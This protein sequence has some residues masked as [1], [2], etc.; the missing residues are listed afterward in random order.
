MEVGRQA[1]H[2]LLVAQ[3]NR[4]PRNISKV[5][6]QISIITSYRTVITYLYTLRFI[7]KWKSPVQGKEH[8]EQSLWISR[9][10][11]APHLHCPSQTPGS[12]KKIEAIPLLISQMKASGRFSK[13]YLELGVE[14]ELGGV[15]NGAC[16]SARC[17]AVYSS[18]KLSCPQT[19]CSF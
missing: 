1:L 13:S 10:G 11:M 15:N 14:D 4:F 5:W 9:P 2:N 12:Q 16:G 8:V 19:R 18:Q 7:G 6:P 3:G 17:K